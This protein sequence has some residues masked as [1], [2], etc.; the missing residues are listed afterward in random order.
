[1]AGPQSAVEDPTVSCQRI[2]TLAT[3]PVRPCNQAD[4]LQTFFELLE[5]HSVRYCVLHSFEHLPQEVLSDLDIAVHPDDRPKLAVVFRQ[6]SEKGYRPIQCLNYA[7]GA[8]YFVFF[9][10]EGSALQ[11]VALDV[12]FEHRRN[13][14]I[15][16]AG[17]DL[18]LGRRRLG[19]IWAPHPSVE[20]EYL[21][22]KKILKGSVPAHQAERLNALV[23]ELGKPKAEA[24]AGRLFGSSMASAVV[25]V[26]ISQT[27]P[28]LLNRLARQ[29]W[30]TAVCKNPLNPI[31]NFLSEIA[32]RR[33]RWFAPT[34]IFL[35]I[36][37]PDGVGKSTLVG[38]LIERLG[39]AFRRHRVF[40]FRPMLIAP[41]DE[42]GIPMTNPHAVPPRGRLGSA[43]RLLGFFLDYWLGYLVLIRPLVARSGL[44]V[45]DRYFHDIL[46]DPRRYR[47]G[48][49]MWL[50][51]L[52][53]PLVP[54]PDSLFLVL[55]ADEEV[56]LSRRREI[57]PSELHRL[58]A[59][60][61]ALSASHSCAALI[62]TDNGVDRSLEDASR[63]I[64]EYMFQRFTL[65][66][67]IWLT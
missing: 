39:P 4:F 61:Q 50:L 45:F 64:A 59:A 9:W 13:G 44:V 17:K 8:F 55:D 27:L 40:H 36:L 10:F 37:G 52:L 7:V 47:Y 56:I 25:D 58:R 5:T 54:P 65:R 12:A 24:I 62:Q 29:L 66:H 3:P 11:S 21:L 20:F 49:P 42:T 63:A 26:C 2:G 16:R 6:L 23:E 31:R 35:V 33:R 34:G 18:V 19:S 41:Q 67:S 60:Y 30:W 28:A 22:A 32:R 1:M 53:A 48:G 38:S 14:L 57:D 46:I 51:R 43:V 15:L